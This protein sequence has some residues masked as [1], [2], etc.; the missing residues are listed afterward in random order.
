V[1]PGE[2]VVLVSLDHQVGPA[3]VVF[4]GDLFGR[5]VV[6]LHRLEEGG[7]KQRILLFHGGIDQP[8]AGVVVGAE[9]APGTEIGVAR[10][11]VGGGLIDLY[12]EAREVRED[13]KIDASDPK[14]LTDQAVA[15][16]TDARNVLPLKS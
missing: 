8:S 4:A 10:S 1:R 2:K 3:E 12:L 6:T 11:D 16:P 13:A 15:V 7:R 9:L 5:T 14:K